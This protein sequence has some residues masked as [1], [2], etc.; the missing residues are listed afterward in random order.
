[1]ITFRQFIENLDTSS[2]DP[3]EIEMGLEVE[4]EHDGKMGKD[5]D[6]VKSKTDLLKIVIAHLREHPKYYSRLK[7][8]ES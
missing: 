6:V 7:K 2:Y 3:K 4:K 5:V 8:V 1:M